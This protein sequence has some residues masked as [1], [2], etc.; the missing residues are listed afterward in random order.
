MIIRAIMFGLTVLVAGCAER[1]A[2][3]FADPVPD[4]DTHMIWSANLRSG[5]APETARVSPPRG[6]ELRFAATEVSVPPTHQTGQVAW[7]RGAPDASTDFAVVA[8]QD[9]ADLGAFSAAIAK[10]DS[11]G[12]GETMLFVHGYNMTHGEAVYQLTQLVHD[13][14]VP[15]PAVLFSWPSAGKAVGYVY[16][17]DSVLLARDALEELIVALTRGSNRKLVIVGHSMGNLLI[18]ETLRQIEITG[19]VDIA[20]QIDGVIMISP[21]IDGELFQAQARRLRTLPDPFLIIA[22][23]QDR[24]LRVSAFLTGRLTR[25][26]SST[27]Q[28][29]VGDL[30]IEVIDFS[31]YGEGG[32]D[33]SIGLTSPAAIAIAKRLNAQLLVDPQ[34]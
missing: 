19:S 1:G 22:A 2:L 32:L 4:A 11:P 5:I 21:D 8:A 18:M 20:R 33:H 28:S 34:R 12:M 10:S 23:S 27:D 31:G 25:L 17:R 3:E 30:P 26:G 7:P 15:S 13:F 16:D 24:A 9:Y 14:E 6:T 29:A